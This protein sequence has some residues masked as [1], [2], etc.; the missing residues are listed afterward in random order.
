MKKIYNMPKLNTISQILSMP[1][2]SSS[3]EESPFLRLLY[4][5]RLTLDTFHWKP[6][7]R[8]WPA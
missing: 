5:F 8:L 6:L 2:Q 4:C 3:R 7:G 1:S